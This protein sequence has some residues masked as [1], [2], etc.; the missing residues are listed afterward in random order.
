MSRHLENWQVFARD[1][2]DGR[3][4]FTAQAQAVGGAVQRYTHPHQQGPDGQTLSV[5]VAR[6]GPEKASR[7]LL[8]ISGTHGLEGAAGSAAQVAWL[9]TDAATA[10]PA[11]TNVVLVHAINP[12]GWAH[13]TR[14][15]ENNVDLNRNFI[16]FSH[17]PPANAP[18][19]AL[20]PHLLPPEWTDAGQAAV[21]QA[22][23]DFRSIHGD[24]ATFNATASGQYNHPDGLV[25]GGQQRE[26]S[27]L[28]LE[29]I[30][31]DYLGHSEKVALIDWHT[32]IGEY[33]EPF[34]LCFNEEGSQEQQQ[35]AAWWGSERVL[36]QRP[37]GLARPNYQGLVFRGVERFLPG[38][39]IAGAVVEF[40]TRGRHMREALR[41]DQWLRFHAAKHPDATRDHNLRLDLIDAFVPYSGVWR[42]SVTRHG[43]QITDQALHGLA[44][45]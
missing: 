28:T 42:Q 26:W 37:H 6:L 40:G 3:A 17:A 4:R 27:N 11:D 25:Y 23:E 30:L 13:Q 35:A 45:W 18:Y 1:Y 9:A 36:D 44:A 22:I 2:A 24:D 15:T 20:H 5:D 12:Y 39:R 16:D 7:T 41:L 10:L 8:L 32:G 33:G 21:R 19:D 14:T 43:V 34:F 29:S 38:R 31:G